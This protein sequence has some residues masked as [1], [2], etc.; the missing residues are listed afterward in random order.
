MSK[1]TSLTWFAKSDTDERMR[2]QEELI[3][4]RNGRDLPYF[5][6]TQ[7]DTHVFV[8]LFAFHREAGILPVFMTMVHFGEQNNYFLHFTA[9]HAS[10][11]AH[12]CF[13]HVTKQYPRRELIMSLLSF[14]KDSDE[15]ILFWFQYAAKNTQNTELLA[16]VEQLISEKKSDKHFELF[17][18]PFLDFR[19]RQFAQDIALLDKQTVKDYSIFFK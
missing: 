5:T 10:F 13:P 16:H 4:V 18:Y 3:S 17:S 7:Y 14:T 1:M 15:N 9:E 19:L 8:S 2:L 11:V 12:H 6:S